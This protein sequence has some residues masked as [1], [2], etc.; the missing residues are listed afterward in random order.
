MRNVRFAVWVAALLVVI[1][2]GTA[3]AT[4]TATTAPARPV[5]NTFEAVE[6]IF[7]PGACDTVY[8]VRSG[9]TLHRRMTVQVRAGNGVGLR[10]TASGDV[11]S[12][13]RVDAA[14]TV[15]NCFTTFAGAAGGFAAKAAAL[16]GW[17]QARQLVPQ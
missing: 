2:G 15:A 16:E 6:V 12:F 5:I 7:S 13:R 17:H 4:I 11:E 14:I 10:Y 9:A 3:L 8:E 1:G